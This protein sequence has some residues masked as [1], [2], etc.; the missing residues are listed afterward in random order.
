MCS[1]KFNRKQCRRACACAEACLY[2]HN[3]ISS[4]VA[5]VTIHD[6]MKIFL[7]DV[8]KNMKPLWKVE[9]FFNRTSWKVSDVQIVRR[10]WVLSSFSVSVFVSLSLSLCVVCCVLLWCSWLWWWWREERRREG[11]GERER[12][13][14]PSGP[15]FP[16]R[17]LKLNSL[18]TI[19]WLI[20][21]TVS[22]RR[23]GVEQLYQVERMIGG[24]GHMLFS[25]YSQ[26]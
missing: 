13:I 5:S 26:T 22:L 15:K 9:G 17:L 25:I 12:L 11:G 14:E 8:A 24:I 19:R 16:S 6:N 3:S 2:P 7:R 23:T 18:V 4:V 10:T 20:P 1:K 21:S